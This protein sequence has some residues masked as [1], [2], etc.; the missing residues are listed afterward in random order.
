MKLKD[1]IDK[2]IFTYSN[3]FQNVVATEFSKS[4]KKL[5]QQIRDDSPSSANSA[6]ADGMEKEMPK[7]RW[8]YKNSWKATETLNNPYFVEY[9]VHNAK[10]YQLAHLLEYGHI[11]V[12]GSRTIGIP[13]IEQ[14]AKEIEEELISNIGKALERL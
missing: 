9:V 13:H 10:K 12:D 8:H 14:N 6:Y 2:I 4:S 3:D 7:K 5:A 1:Q 11:N